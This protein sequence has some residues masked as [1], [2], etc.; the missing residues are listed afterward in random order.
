MMYQFLLTT[1]ECSNEHKLRIAIKRYRLS[2]RKCRLFLT[3]VVYIQVRFRLDFI[4]EAKNMTPDK[5]NVG[6][7]TCNIGYLRLQAEERADDKSR[8]WREKGK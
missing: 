1:S 4:M 7:I 3:S 2:L 6:H 5:T 8:D